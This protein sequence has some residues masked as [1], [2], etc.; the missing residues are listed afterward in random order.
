MSITFR[1][2]SGHTI[3][4]FIASVEQA[5]QVTPEDMRELAE[6]A[7]QGIQEQT[8]RGLDV[9]GAPMESYKDSGPY[10]YNPSTNGGK[11]AA[12]TAHLQRK[13]ARQ[14][15][16]RLQ[17][18]GVK[19]IKLTSTHTSIKFPTYAAFKEAYGSVVPD[20]YGIGEPHMLKAI[21]YRIDGSDTAVLFI[22]GH[23]ERPRAAAHNFGDRVKERRF[24]GFNDNILGKFSAFF[25]GRFGGIK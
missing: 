24:W 25:A 15:F 18:G 2:N 13:V 16:E 7:K 11:L 1:S 9:D 6:I 19:G 20:L 8:L 22:R 17:R 23:E 10:Y 5:T 4:E 14:H 12:P 3:D 21:D